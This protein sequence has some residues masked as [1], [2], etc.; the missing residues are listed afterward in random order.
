MR[1]EA[2]GQRGRLAAQDFEGRGQQDVSER[3][4]TI[5]DNIV[6]RDPERYLAWLSNMGYFYF[7]M[8]DHNP[9][10]LS[11]EDWCAWKAP[12]SF[13]L[14]CKQA[15][16]V[17]RPTFGSG[18]IDKTKYGPIGDRPTMTLKDAKKGNKRAMEF[19]ETADGLEVSLKEKAQY[20]MIGGEATSREAAVLYH[21]IRGEDVWL[22]E[23]VD[24]IKKAYVNPSRRMEAE[25][26]ANFHSQVLAAESRGA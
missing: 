19:I 24:A 6:A 25:I 18:S 23:P 22:A 16:D 3:I 9:Y 2:D 10:A 26:E 5:L 20:S 8:Y 12:R 15:S 14:C 4:T 11:W 17:V 21:A 13:E 1:L 7:T